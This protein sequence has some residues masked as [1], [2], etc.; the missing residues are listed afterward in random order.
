MVD[1][2]W[3]GTMLGLETLSD[4]Y[5]LSICNSRICSWAAGPAVA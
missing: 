4:R 5:K 1:Q 3:Q 2:V